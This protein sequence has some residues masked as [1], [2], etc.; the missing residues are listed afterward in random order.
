VLERNPYY[1]V[2]TKNGDQLP[3]IDT[4]NFTL[5]Q[6]AQVIKLHIQ[7][8]KVDYCHGNANQIDLGDYST[9]LKSA[10]QGNCGIVQWASGSAT[11]SRFFLNRHYP[12]DKCRKLSRDKRFM[13]AISHGWA[14]QT[15]QKTLYFET[16]ELTTGTMS[17]KAME[18]RTGTQGPQ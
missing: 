7:S 11:G 4:I 9:L 2:V 17:P 18:W 12:N 1:W 13:R 16:G 3:Y 10:T 5:V 14:R 8:G 15:T 6:N